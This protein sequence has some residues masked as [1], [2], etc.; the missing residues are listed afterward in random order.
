VRFCE[1]AAAPFGKLLLRTLVLLVLLA[2]T[3]TAGPPAVRRIFS[4]KR[5]EKKKGE[6][7]LPLFNSFPHSHSL[8]HPQVTCVLI[9]FQRWPSKFMASP[10]KNAQQEMIISSVADA[11]SSP[12]HCDE[13]D[14]AGLAIPHTPLSR[15]KNLRD[16]TA[17]DHAAACWTCGS[18]CMFN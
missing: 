4:K 2:T 11:S 18:S 16:R 7:T 1:R 13:K 5:E 14:A 17:T 12:N 6:I 8:Q 10:Q 9:V 15:S 3:V